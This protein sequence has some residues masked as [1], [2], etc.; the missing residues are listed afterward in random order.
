MA[1]KKPPPAPKRPL[2]WEKISR[3]SRAWWFAHKA[4]NGPSAADI[5]FGHIDSFRDYTLRRRNRSL[6]AAR[7][8]GDDLASFGEKMTHEEK[9]FDTFSFN[10]M[11]SGRRAIAAKVTA[12]RTMPFIVT[13]GGSFEEREN[14]EEFNKVCVGILEDQGV[15]DDDYQYAVD[16]LT[17]EGAASKVTARFGEVWIERIKFWELLFDPLDAR[18]GWRGLRTLYHSFLID[19]EQLLSLFPNL[20]ELDQGKVLSA[21]LDDTDRAF[22]STSNPDMVRV[23]EGWHLPS[24]PGA[25][26][27]RHFIGIRGL[28]LLDEAY[29][30]ETFPIAVQYQEPPSQGICQQSFIERNINAQATLDRMTNDMA[31]SVNTVSKSRVWAKAGTFMAELDDSN[32]KVYEYDGNEPPRVDAAIPFHPASFQFMQWMSDGITGVE[33]VSDMSSQGALP[34]GLA[35]ASGKALIVADDTFSE[36]LSPFMHSRQLF[37]CRLGELAL[38]VARELAAENSGYVVSIVDGKAIRRVKFKDIDIGEGNYKILVQPASYLSKSPSAKYKQLSEMRA[39]GDIGPIEF[40]KLMGVPDLEAANEL[41]TAMQ[42]V[43]DKTIYACMSKGLEAVAQPFDDLKL[44]ISRGTKAYHLARVKDLPSDRQE[45]VLNYVRSAYDEQQRQAA[46]SAPPPSPPGMPG[47]AP[48]PP[49]PGGP[50]P[51]DMGPFPPGMPPMGPPGPP[52]PPPMP[53]GMPPLAA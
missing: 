52:M 19:R 45:A 44:I 29:T 2:P 43:V 30:Y 51:P 41:D 53:G 34:Q 18:N 32:L 3:V 7:K 9:D 17:H 24:A 40:R 22:Y 11:R 48:V 39:N 31:D 21:T 42:D 46:T 8:V 28:T 4:P 16:A 35:G 5:V 37:Y 6:N 25:E 1:A 33:G 36:Q 50:M 13:E 27:G 20:D 23:I 47:P 12:T 49:M 10:R 15:Y 38:Q 14:A 26:D